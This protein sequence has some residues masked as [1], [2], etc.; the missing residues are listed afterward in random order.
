M[1]FM[2]DF[3]LCKT[4]MIN[5]YAKKNKKSF[6]TTHVPTIYKR[7]NDINPFLT[8]RSHEQTAK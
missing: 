4:I 6:Y 2:L 7:I 3:T 5:W 8:L 1:N